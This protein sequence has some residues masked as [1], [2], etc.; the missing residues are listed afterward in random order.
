MNVLLKTYYKVNGTVYIENDGKTVQT[1]IA[2]TSQSC[3][4]FSLRHN[5]NPDHNLTKKG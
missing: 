4:F 3:D 5:D 2:A 1:A